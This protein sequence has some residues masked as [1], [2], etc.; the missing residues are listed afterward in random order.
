MNASK[1]SRDTAAGAVQTIA[2]QFVRELADELSEGKIELPSFPDIALRVQRVLADDNVT[3][4]RVVRVVGS[5]PALAAKI[6][7]MANS[8]ALTLNGRQITDLKMAISRMGFD[9]VRSAAMSFALAQLRNAEQYRSL[10]REMNQLWQRSVLVAAMAFVIAKR[11]TKIGPDTAMLT[12]LLHGVG[13]LYI[14]THAS[15][16][17]AL[18]GD[19]AGYNQIVHDWHSSIAKALLEN[20][21]MAEE[22]V[23]SVHSFDDAE[24]DLRAP[25]GLV[26]VIAA[27]QLFVVFKDEP[28]LL[29]ARLHESKAHSRLGIDAVARIAIAQESAEEIA[30]LKAALG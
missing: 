4:D 25:V 23:E 29:A 15:K 22:I 2:F 6:L 30:A 17:P 19:V 24:R 5:E 3:P 1:K 11:H 28:D 13:K 20:W 14:L 26:D 9:M 7:M 16:H 8:A 27:A 12:G 18:F 10:A 21:G